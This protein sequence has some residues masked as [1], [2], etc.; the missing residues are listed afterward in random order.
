MGVGWVAGFSEK[1]PSQP[2]TKAGVGAELGNKRKIQLRSK[3]LIVAKNKNQGKLK[4]LKLTC[5]QKTNVFKLVTGP[6]SVLT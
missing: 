6:E 3:R 1:K 5:D 4:E 2:Q